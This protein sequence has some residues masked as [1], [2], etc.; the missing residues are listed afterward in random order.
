M[1]L[2]CS[3]DNR[4]VPFSLMRWRGSSISVS[5]SSTS[6]AGQSRDIRVSRAVVGSGEVR[7]TRIISSI[8]ATAIARPTRIW[9]RSRALASRNLVRRV[10]TRSRKSTKI[11]SRSF[12]C[13]IR[14]RPLSSA[15]ML[16]PKLVC[17]GVNLYS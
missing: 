15:T 7:M 1:A 17:S 4:I 14:G 5:M 2:A 10:T 13:M 11:A 16:T 8:L 9:A 6:R 3:I 12:R